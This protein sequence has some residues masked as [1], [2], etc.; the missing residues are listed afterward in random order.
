MP[1]RL[2]QIKII[3]ALILIIMAGSVFARLA[4]KGKSDQTIL[5]KRLVR[6]KPQNLTISPDANILRV[7][8]KFKEESEVRLRSGKLVSLK[9]QSLK[10][11][12]DVLSPYQ[13]SRLQRLINSPEENLNR[14][15]SA[16]E[17]SSGHK[18]ADLNLYYKIELSD[19]AEAE[20]IVNELNKLDIVEMAYPDPKT[21]PAVDLDPPTP[22]FEPYQFYRDPAPDGVD[23]DYANTI[24]GGDGSGV[25]I[26]DIENEWNED[27]EDLEKAVGGTLSGGNNPYGNHGTAVLGEMIAGDDDFGVTGICP[28][29]DVG[30]ASAQYNGT[31][32][33]MWMAID[34][35]EAGDLMLIELHS[36]GPR[37]NFQV[38]YDQ[39]GYVCMEYWQDR[40]DA[41]QYA[42]A[43]GIIVIEAAGN[44][45]EDYDDPIYEN[46]F[47][48]TYRN[49]HAIIAGAGAPISGA[50][51]T[52]RS[53]LDFS[54]YGERVNLQG[55]GREVVT[56]GY[57]D[58]FDGAGSDPYQYY[59]STFSGT[60]SASPI[61][62]GAVACLQ[63]YYEA[64]YGV[65]LNS[66]QARD[67]L[68]S[69]GSA[70]QGDTIEHI[71]PLPN[72]AA[73]F[74]AAT[75]PPSVFTI[76]IY[77]DT[78][79]EVNTI[80]N[81]PLWIFNRSATSALDFSI[82]DNDSLLKLIPDWLTATPQNGTVAIGD[83]IEITVSFDAT[84][85]P[86]TTIPYKGILEIS[87]NIS[88][89]S[90]DSMLL[91]PVFLDIPCAEDTVFEVL[92]SDNPGGP[93]YN[94][95]EIQSIGT[96]IPH[97]S[98]YNI[99]GGDPLDDGS[100]GPFTLPFDFPYFENLYNEVYIGVN[101][102][103]SFTDSEL[104]SGGY[105]GD[106]DIPD[107]PFETFIAV[108]WNDLFI[109]D[110]DGHG[111]IYYYFS[112]TDDTA[113]FEWYQVGNFNSAIDT[114]T[115]FQIILTANGNITMQY[116]D[117]GET[118]QENTALIALDEIGCTSHPYLDHS[119]PA[120][121]LI[122]DAMTVQFA[123]RMEYLQ[124]GDCNNDGDIN[125]FD[126]TFLITYLYKGGPPPDP[127]A[128]G[129]PNCDGVV[130]IFDVT[131]LISHL[132]KEGAAPCFFW[133]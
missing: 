30:M 43:K 122:T 46:L 54:N 74:A 69:T 79:L 95:I 50:S 104:N 63:G 34:T 116:Q 105:Y 98:Y 3:I 11:V 51:G 58:L 59:T 47:D 107:A 40:Y 93:T 31:T 126:I 28:G 92:A 10:S 32:E 19:P 112:P 39:L 100:A 18:L 36:P 75:P 60:S 77:F 5:K 65:P 97:Y 87:W 127:Y 2:F 57:G 119:D 91:V 115:T 133:G 16:Y 23:A 17:I 96:V 22:A 56:T 103:V 9:G 94:W 38:R 67:I 76:P 78:T 88:G 82:N 121:N 89:L 53:R 132:Y 85:I 25:K 7:I 101:G 61:V 29:A 129:D 84:I 13:S 66:D 55:Y 99:Y 131:F 21:E 118:G 6:N 102:G 64:T 15:K 80:A 124:S 24:A 110:G 8:V 83:S 70:Q 71:G 73:A 113:I 62:T 120:E 49:S 125:I 81:A 37:Y 42:W 12:N 128:A 108:F 114:M 109:G 26:I 4:D 117:V 130:N 111:D 20:I 68:I 44:G 45:A 33:A 90:L 1:V 14:L 41:L 48:T 106:F 52:P 27:H 72:L 35:L 123:N 86:D